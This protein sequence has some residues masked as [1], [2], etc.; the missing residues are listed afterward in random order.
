MKGREKQSCMQ[1][2]EREKKHGGTNMCMKKRT[3][4]K[5]KTNGSGKNAS[6]YKQIGGYISD[7][8]NAIQHINRHCCIAHI[9]TCCS[10][11]VTQPYKSSRS[12]LFRCNYMHLWL[13][14]FGLYSS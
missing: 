5:Q 3:R 7:E 12:D 13:T 9:Y 8:T 10:W 11:Q 14:N 2:R 6:L 4:N 1:E